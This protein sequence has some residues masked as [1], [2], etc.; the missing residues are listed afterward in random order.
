MSLE[1]EQDGLFGFDFDEDDFETKKERIIPEQADYQA[2]IETDG[3]HVVELSKNIGTH[4]HLYSGFMKAVK[5]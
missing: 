4:S 1:E 3:V 5:A 2:K